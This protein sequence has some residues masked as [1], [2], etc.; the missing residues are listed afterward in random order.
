[1][2]E[3]DALEA[4]TGDGCPA[5]GKH[6]AE[7]SEPKRPKRLKHDEAYKLI[8]SNKDYMAGL[9]AG[10][11]NSAWA[12]R[13]DLD[14]LVLIHNERVDDH[15]VR[16]VD[17]LV[18]QV[19]LKGSDNWLKILVLVELQSSV[20]HY[21]ALRVARYGVA[22]YEKQRQDRGKG[23]PKKMLPAGA[24]VLH[25][26]SG[27]WTAKQQLTDLVEPVPEEFRHLLVTVAYEV[28]EQRQPP[29]SGR[30]GPTNPAEAVLRLGRAESG[31]EIVQ[32]GRAALRALEGRGDL[33][34]LYVAFVQQ[35]Y[36][37]SRFPN[38]TFEEK[39][40]MMALQEMIESDV[41]DLQAKAKASGRAEGRVEGRVEGRAEERVE[42]FDS[43]R[44][45]IVEP[46]RRRLGPQAARE[47]EAALAGVTQLESLL[48]AYGWA[49]TCSSRAELIAR[50]LTL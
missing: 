21:M 6:A 14:S 40:S 36:L 5:S 37:Q 42:I 1:M 29:E 18:W 20:D 16:L 27:R 33:Q 50:L 23:K 46:T 7:L 15:L 45:R 49:E 24:V 30:V 25:T 8:F 13:V 31:K 12:R 28:V 11:V 43:M 32:A 17:D 47:A 34:D 3:K 39:G 48:T 19:K 26:G 44:L 4:E 41:V 10:F 2:T 35:Y 9:L 22:A 38:E